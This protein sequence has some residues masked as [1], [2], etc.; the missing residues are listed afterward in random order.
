MTKPYLSHFSNTMRRLGSLE[1]TIM[2]EKVEGG[3]KQGRPSMRW[4]D[5]IID[6]IVMSVQEPSRA[7]EDWTLWTSLLHRVSKNQSQLNGM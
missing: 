6:A 5:S 4:I 1:K 2:L 3:R 7:V